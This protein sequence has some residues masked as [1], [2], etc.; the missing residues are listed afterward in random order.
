MKNPPLPLLL[1]GKRL[2][3]SPIR[4]GTRQG[5]LLSSCLV[6][7]TLEVLAREIKQEIKGIQIREE[8]VKLSLF[9]NYLILYIE[10]TNTEF[11]KK[12]L[13]QISSARWWDT[14]SIHKN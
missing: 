9:T 1:N 14:R 5:Y 6:N 7:P 3:A 8:E 4:S 11:T 13:E 12:V 10:N 2:K